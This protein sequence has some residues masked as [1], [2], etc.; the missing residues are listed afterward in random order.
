VRLATDERAETTFAML[1]DCF[2]VLG[3]IP[4]TVLAERMGCLKGSVVA[5]VVVPTRTTCARVPNKVDRLSCVRFAS[6]RYSVPTRLI[7]TQVG[8]HTEDGRVLVIVAANGE[9]VAEHTLVAPGVA[10]IRDEHYG[11]P[12]PAPGGRVR[13][14]PLPSNS[15]ARSDPPPKRS[16]PAPPQPGTPAAARN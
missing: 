6:V 2:E 9:A 1:A 10:S 3:G 14:D 12:R 11:G 16:P 4:G 15:S 13:P 8:I 7:G 5:N